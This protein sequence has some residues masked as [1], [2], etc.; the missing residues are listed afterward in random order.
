MQ[1]LFRNRF[2]G[3][4]LFLCHRKQTLAAN[5][6][7]HCCSAYHWKCFPH[8]RHSK[9]TCN[10]VARYYDSYNHSWYCR[11]QV[12]LPLPISKSEDVVASSAVPFREISTTSVS[13]TEPCPRREIAALA[14][15]NQPSTGL[16]T[17]HTEQRPRCERRPHT[18][19]R[20]T[21]CV[22]S[23]YGVTVGGSFL[24][25]GGIFTARKGTV[26]FDGVRIGS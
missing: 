3:K 18:Q 11:S 23:N 6:W 19:W 10:G 2:A 14:A 15:G 22:S 4:Q 17:S 24:N 12:F 7:Y 20:N 8:P 9:H 1:A 21:R 16:G 5:K 13:T 26:T 25:N